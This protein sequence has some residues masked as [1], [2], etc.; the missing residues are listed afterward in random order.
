MRTMNLLVT[1]D[2]NYLPPLYVLLQSVFVN[3]PQTAFDVYMIYDS[4]REE[5]V[6]ALSDFCTA[7]GGRLYPIEAQEDFFRGA[8]VTSRLPRAMY[9]RL[10]AR[11]LLPGSLD[12]I[13]YLDPDIVVINPLDRLYDADLDGFLFAGAAHTDITGVTE[14]VN[15][16]RLQYERPGYVNTGVLL[17]NLDLQRKELQKEDIFAYIDEHKHELILPDQDVL[18]GLYG[19]RV[20]LLDDSLYNY[21]AHRYETYRIASGGVKTLDWVMQNTV[22]IHF[23]GKKK[24]WIKSS[25]GRYGILYQHYAAMVRRQAPGR[26]NS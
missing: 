21:A 24:P 1:L 12:R 7:H 11:Y 18:N 20:L 19:K 2:E 8:P 22:I 26:R 14:R 17:L 9:Y 15:Q 4:I 3:N 5:R 13:L 25:R 10:L 6:A 16:L 23:C